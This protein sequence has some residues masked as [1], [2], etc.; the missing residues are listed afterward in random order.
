MEGEG[1]RRGRSGGALAGFG[2]GSS[3]SG[4]RSGGPS[5]SVAEATAAM[6]GEKEAAGG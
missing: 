4:W 6:E 3:R 5:P 1:A 2:I